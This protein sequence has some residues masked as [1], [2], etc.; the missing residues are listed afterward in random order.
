M[1]PNP[2]PLVFPLDLKKELEGDTPPLLVDVR[3]EEE[4]SISVLPGDVWIPMHE[5]PSRF[6][7]LDR[8]RDIVVYCRTGNR[9][10]QVV[11]FM[12]RYGFKQVRNLATGINGWAADVDPSLPQY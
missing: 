10:G 1:I 8:E 3:E 9:S 7:E 6:G 11:A 2:V 4:R 5:I 12:R